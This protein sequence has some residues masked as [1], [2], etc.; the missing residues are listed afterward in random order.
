MAVMPPAVP[1]PG[2]GLLL[3]TALAGAAAA[4]LRRKRRG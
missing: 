2:A 1:L 4:G 3:G